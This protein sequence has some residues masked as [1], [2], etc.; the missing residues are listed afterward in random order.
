MNEKI[1]L[2]G[3]VACIE[4]RVYRGLLE[5]RLRI[6][7]PSGKGEVVYLREPPEWLKPGIRVRVRAIM[8]RQTKEHRYIVEEIAVVENKADVVEMNVEDIQRGVMTVISGKKEGRLYSITISNELSSRLPQQPPTTI[9]L[10]MINTRVGWILAE[11][12]YRILARTLE[13]LEAMREYYSE[14]NLFSA[15]K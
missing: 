14:E 13:L 12:E 11:K 3:Y 10:V 8:S 9:Y 5:Y 15:Q 7:G 4:P 6:V 1:A 2:E